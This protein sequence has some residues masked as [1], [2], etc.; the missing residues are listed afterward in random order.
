M[1]S[2]ETLSANPVIA[3]AELEA[4]HADAYS[5]A[6]TRCG[7][8]R[9]D[10]ADLLQDAYARLLDGS[11]RF[12]GRSTLRSFLFGVIDRIAREQRRRTRIR[13][14]LLGR[15]GDVLA[16]PPPALPQ[17]E[18]CDAE[19][20]Q[21][22]AALRTLSAR[23]RDVLELVFYRDCSIEEAAGILGL[24]VGT[25]RTHYQRGKQSLAAK[26]TVAT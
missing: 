11:A 9:P 25:A 23:Q 26:L 3:L 17:D 20:G 12:D 15:F 21:L 10:A 18:A 2:R 13:A 4:V 7:Y 5:W 16:P 14:L 24:P 8:S 6:L 22:R 1:A 19:I